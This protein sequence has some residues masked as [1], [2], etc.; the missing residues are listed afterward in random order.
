MLNWAAPLTSRDAYRPEMFLPFIVK[1]EQPE[2]LTRF[3]PEVEVTEIITLVDDDESDDETNCSRSQVH[4]P[5][6]MK[7]HSLL[8]YLE[9]SNLPPHQMP[10]SSK[11][12]KL[13]Q[14]YPG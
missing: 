4:G 9:D 12:G 2:E 6:P 10:C 1:C 8:S 14:M 3:V 11:H 13:N 5:L 7:N